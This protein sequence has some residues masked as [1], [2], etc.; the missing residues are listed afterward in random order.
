MQFRVQLYVPEKVE[1]LASPLGGV[2]YAIFQRMDQFSAVHEIY[3]FQ[4][5]V[6]HCN[7]PC[8]DSSL[9]LSHFHG[10]SDSLG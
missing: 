3:T 5:A 9:P 1:A 7:I 4:I 2:V 6:H 8:C 10:F